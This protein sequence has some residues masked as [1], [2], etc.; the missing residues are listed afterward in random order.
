MNQSSEIH[1]LNEALAKAQGSFPPIAKNKTAKVKSQRTNTEFS[2]QYADLSDVLSAAIPKLTENGLSIRQPLRDTP[3]G[4][5]LVT[6]LHHSSGQWTSDDGLPLSSGLS[7]QDFGIE[8]SY[9]RRYG[10]CGMLGIAPGVNEES[11]LGN[12]SKNKDRQLKDAGSR[13][14]RAMGY[15]APQVDEALPITK[16]QTESLKEALKKNGKK[17]A[18]LYEFLELKMGTPIPASRLQSALI[19]VGS[20]VPAEMPTKVSDAFNI[21]G[22]SEFERHTLIEKHECR[23]DEIYSTLNQMIETEDA[24]QS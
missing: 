17:A 8:H 19:W 10:A 1:L 11:E 18:A 23:W 3:K 14:S 4:M 20:P 12:L 13:N 15:T 6:E 9:M 24:Q 22:W 16:E 7:P 21:L 2:Y 5:R